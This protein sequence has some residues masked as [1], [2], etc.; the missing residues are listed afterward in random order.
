MK[1]LP[2]AS[3]PTAQPRVLTVA[4]AGA[5]RSWSDLALDR[6]GRGS[7][8]AGVRY[9]CYRDGFAAAVGAVAAGTR[10]RPCCRLAGRAGLTTPQAPVRH[11]SS[12]HLR[13]QAHL[14][15]A[16]VSC[17]IEDIDK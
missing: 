7:G 4:L 1:P 17:H 2:I 13:L 3:P 14:G 12:C 5:P 6:S 11:F 10:T 8:R 15:E 9:A 16:E